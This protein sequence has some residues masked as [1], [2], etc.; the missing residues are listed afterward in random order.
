MLIAFL[1]GTVLG[2]AIA[3]LPFELDTTGVGGLVMCILS[4]AWLG[5]GMLLFMMVPM[6]SP[7][8]TTAMHTFMCLAGGA[9]FSFGLGAVSNAALNKTNLIQKRTSTDYG[10]ENRFFVPQQ[11][12][13]GTGLT[14]SMVFLLFISAIRLVRRDKGQQ[15]P[16]LHYAPLHLLL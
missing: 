3:G 10:N 16:A 1:I 2:G 15:I 9:C 4:K 14:L 11:K 7:L 12:D 8:D 6:P 13:H 5:G